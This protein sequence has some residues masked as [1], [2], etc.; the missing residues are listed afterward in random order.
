MF[1]EQPES[2]AGTGGGFSGLQRQQCQGCVCG[3]A[4]CAEGLWLWVTLSGTSSPSDFLCRFW[5]MDI[6]AFATVQPWTNPLFFQFLQK[7]NC[8]QVFGQKG[9]VQGLHQVFL[10]I[11][12]TTWNTSGWKTLLEASCPDT[13]QNVPFFKVRLHYPSPRKAEIWKSWGMGMMQLLREKAQE[14]K[15]QAGMWT[16]RTGSVLN[17]SLGLCST[18]VSTGFA[19]YPWKM[20]NVCHQTNFVNINECPLFCNN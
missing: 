14:R 1:T 18:P 10:N 2:A 19:V 12:L 7:Q 11:L 20:Q 6:L 4:T 13:F 16:K 9:I 17:K 5:V 3:S 15:G 8:R